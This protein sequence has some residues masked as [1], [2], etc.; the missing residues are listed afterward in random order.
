MAIAGTSKTKTVLE[1]EI[2]PLLERLLS[3]LCA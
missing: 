2:L 3:K 1:K